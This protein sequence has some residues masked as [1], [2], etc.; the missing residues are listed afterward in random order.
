[1]D[2]CELRLERVAAALGHPRPAEYAKEFD[3]EDLLEDLRAYVS[4]GNMSGEEGPYGALPDVQAQQ[5]QLTDTQIGLA[6]AQLR[7]QELE[8]ALRQVLAA[9]GRRSADARRTGT[10]HAGQRRV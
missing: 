6:R 5:Q 2:P 4:S 8:D 1:M 3:L 10:H 7:A 9:V